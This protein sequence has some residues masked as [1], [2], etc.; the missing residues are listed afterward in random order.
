MQDVEETVGLMVSLT[1]QTVSEAADLVF[2]AIHALAARNSS[3]MDDRGGLASNAWDA[4]TR[5]IP[6][7]G[8]HGEV[9]AAKL[10]EAG[11]QVSQATITGSE[12]ASLRDALAAR[13]VDFAVVRNAD[14]CADV[15]FRAADFELMSGALAQVGADLGL[16]SADMQLAAEQP[17]QGQADPAPSQDSPAARWEEPCFGVEWS[18]STASAEAGSL[19]GQLAQCDLSAHADGSWAVSIAGVQRASG[20][21]TSED[22]TGAMIDA[23]A[24]ARATVSGRDLFAGVAWQQGCAP[25][26]SVGD[27]G[28]AP[29]AEKGAPGH[30]VAN[31]AKQARERAAKQPAREMKAPVPR[32]QSR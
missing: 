22:I 24:S 15:L 11:A 5:R 6:G 13:G 31:V 25:S 16:S 10:H 27:D 12:L 4:L 19:E 18:P 29:K 30:T 9:S 2:K 3:R 17:C 8:E 26:L 32:R 21:A 28:H 23:A 14:G 1:N 20:T 7:I